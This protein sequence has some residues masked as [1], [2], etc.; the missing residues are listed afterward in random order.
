MFTQCVLRLLHSA[1]DNLFENLSIYSDKK[2]EDLTPILMGIIIENVTVLTDGLGSIVKKAVKGV[3]KAAKNIVS[4]DL[5]KAA[6]LA[7]GA[8][9]AGGGNL[10]GLTA[11]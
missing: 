10:F 5:G 8:Y 7:G 9:Y 1:G 4:S 11:T 2:N 3:S 6:L